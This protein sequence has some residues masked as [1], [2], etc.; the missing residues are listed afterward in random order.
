LLRSRG[1]RNF[2][3]R[4]LAQ[5][6]IGRCR[7]FSNAQHIGGCTDYHQGWPTIPPVPTGEREDTPLCFAISQRFCRFTIEFGSHRHK[8]TA[9]PKHICQAA[10]VGRHEGIAKAPD[11]D[12]FACDAQIVRKQS[13][14]RGFRAFLRHTALA[15]D[16]LSQ[17]RCQR[18]L[19]LR[20]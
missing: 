14:C 5:D 11:R 19:V 2:Q 8:L 15:Q 12:A 20:A 4:Q 16:R 17:F 18:R 6:G 9:R 10:C 13:G 7:T 1:C 3:S